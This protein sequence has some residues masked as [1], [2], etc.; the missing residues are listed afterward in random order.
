MN[1]RGAGAAGDLNW[2]TMIMLIEAE[3]KGVFWIRPRELAGYYLA[4]RSA[5]QSSASRGRAGS[6]G[7]YGVTV[8]SNFVPSGD[9]PDTDTSHVS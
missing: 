2:V 6:P 7:T 1:V 5:I 8:T 9:K 3:R 4:D